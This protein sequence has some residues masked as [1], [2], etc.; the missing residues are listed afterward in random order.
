MTGAPTPPPPGSPAAC[1]KDVTAARIW[2]LS[3]EQYVQTLVKSFGA[4]NADINQLPPDGIDPVTGFANTAQAAT[5]AGAASDVFD[6][7]EAVSARVA[8]GFDKTWPCLATAPATEDCVR[9]FVTEM[10]RQAFR[11]PV[12]DADIATYVALLRSNEKDLGGRV[13]AEL[14][15]QAMLLSPNFL[16]R[17]ELGLPGG[18]AT[19]EIALDPYEIASALS[20]GLTDGPPD[21]ALMAAAM[22]GQTADLAERARQA[23]RLARSPAAATKLARFMYWQLQLNRLDED[24]VPMSA[25][26]IAESR[27]FVESVANGP[28]STL[29]TLLTASYTI[30]PSVDYAPLY[31]LPKPTKTP[32][33][34]DL[35]PAQRF[36]L[37]TQPGWLTVRHGPILRGRLLRENFLCQ[38]IPMP[39]GNVAD[40]QNDLPKTPPNATEAEKWKAFLAERPSCAACHGVFQPLGLAFE[41][42]AAD[43]RWRAKTPTGAVIDPSGEVAGAEGW[44]G[45]FGNARDLVGQ[46][47]SS[48][49]G[50]QCFARRLLTYVSGRAVD[51]AQRSCVARRVSEKF[52][53]SGLD[54]HQLMTA[55]ATDETFALRRRGDAP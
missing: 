29:E 45:K 50:R 10:G 34:V 13:A 42:Y 47:V 38:E 21:A 36:G 33:R 22:S 4:T 23:D 1:A 37:L 40:L 55:I 44:S 43:G 25:N 11:R 6:T 31:G 15:L 19:G 35:D 24:P 48:E 9:R 51:D 39:P 27:A 5:L 32:A 30:L 2:R 17:T 12:A 3:G 20:Y 8:Q 16:F 18:P 26:L 53:A 46:I 14:A 7:A 41:T 52:V 49:R 54:I 28:T